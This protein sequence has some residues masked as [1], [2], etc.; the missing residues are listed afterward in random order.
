MTSVSHM[1]DTLVSRIFSQVSSFQEM[2]A[3]EL[4]TDLLK[5]FLVTAVKKS[6]RRA[7]DDF[8]RQYASELAAP[9]PAG[10]AWKDWL[11]LPYVSKP[12][13]DPRFAAC[14][15]EEWATLLETSL[16]NLLSTAF[17]SIP[18]PTL[19][20]F[21]LQRLESRARATEIRALKAKVDTLNFKLSLCNTSS[22]TDP[23]GKQP[24]GGGGDHKRGPNGL[25]LGASGLP[26]EPPSSHSEWTTPQTQKPTATKRQTPERSQNNDTSYLRAGARVDVKGAGKDDYKEQP[27][28]VYRRSPF[29][30]L[31]V[32]PLESHSAAV[33][34]TRFSSDGRR[35]A[36]G[37]KGGTLR[38]WQL[39]E[40]FLGACPASSRSSPYD[41]NASRLL[42]FRH[43]DAVSNASACEL[44]GTVFCRSAVGAVEW[45]IFNSVQCLIADF[46]ALCLIVFQD[47][48]SDELLLCGS[49]D[50]RVGIFD[51]SLRFGLNSL[52]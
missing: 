49:H 22:S 33:R 38:V 44:I 26:R 19:L 39:S 40:Q 52:L 20:A 5:L 27:A 1:W 11:A 6:K 47:P 41:E 37:S 12:A 35:L 21:N 17:Q 16:R 4:R 25:A 15:E 50:S 13:S 36:A 24:E 10:A 14:F 29:L 31:S 45:V 23:D 42:Q 18:L 34:C 48:L 51:R 28:N 3:R 46:V 30:E 32:V 8:F 9:G 7:I 43:A 2:E